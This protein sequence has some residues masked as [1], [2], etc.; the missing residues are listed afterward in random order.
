MKDINKVAELLF[1]KIRS[2]FSNVTLGTESGKNTSDPSQA[3]FFNFNYMSGEKDFGNVTISIIDGVSVKVYF[4]KDLSS[5]LDRKE[6]DEWFEFLRNMRQFA[7]KNTLTFDTRDINRSSLDLR[8]IMQQ[9]KTSIQ[10]TN[11]LDIQESKMYGTKRKSYDH[12]GETRLIIKHVDMVDEEKRGSRTRNIDA[13]FVET[14]EGERY[15]LKTTNLHG[16]RAIGQ[17][18]AQGG[19]MVDDRTNKIYD[20]VT[21]MQQLR[22]FLMATRNVEAFEDTDIPHMVEAARTRYTE[23]QRGLKT[24]RGPKGYAKFWDNHAPSE[25]IEIDDEASLKERFTKKFLD[26]RIEE[27]LPFVYKAY[28]KV[29]EA[30]KLTKSVNDEIDAWADSIMDSNEQPTSEKGSE[31]KEGT[32]HL[33]STDEEVETFKKLMS[34]PLKFGTEGDNATNAI[35]AVFGDDELYDNLYSASEIQGPDGD[36][37]S[38]IV[39]WFTPLWKE[40]T[41]GDHDYMEKEML[42]KIQAVGSYLRTWKPESEPAPADAEG[43]DEEPAPETEDAD[44]SAKRMS[45]L[46]TAIGKHTIQNLPKATKVEAIEELQQLAGLK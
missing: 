35:G 45:M 7:R 23:V 1:D 11:D 15:K 18:V 12:V 2:R 30:G 21:E 16:A 36:A 29:N 4:N 34:K 24:M 40:V 10:Q 46:T 38:T 8:D 17:H 25:E 9:T 27:A 37:R 32:W 28:H 14:A 22:K 26:H 41:N 43:P 39:Q 44:L 6:Q 31:L 20:M 5:N 33:P 3:R 19:M 13:V 42:E